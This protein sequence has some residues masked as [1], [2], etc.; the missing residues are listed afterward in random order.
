M[1]EDG[2]WHDIVDK[3]IE[4]VDFVANDSDYLMK[5]ST[6]HYILKEKEASKG[7]EL[8]GRYMRGLWW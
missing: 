4:G 6:E 1:M 5:L 2:D 7:L 3:M 8:L